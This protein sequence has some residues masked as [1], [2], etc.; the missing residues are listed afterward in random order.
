MW[1]CIY[2][3]RPRLAAQLNMSTGDL[4]MY[5]WADIRQGEPQ[6]S[7]PALQFSVS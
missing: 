2:Y 3:Y 5:V 7:G 4:E 1:G 6:K